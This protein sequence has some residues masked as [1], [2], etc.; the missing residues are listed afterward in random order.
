MLAAMTARWLPSH[1]HL[2]TGV[3]STGSTRPAVSSPR[4]L[5]TART[6]YT[7]ARKAMNMAMWPI[8]PLSISS[9]PPNS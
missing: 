7:A 1:P 8:Y 5:C 4:R 2:L 3:A 9:A 6:A